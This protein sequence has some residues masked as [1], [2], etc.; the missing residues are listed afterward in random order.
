MGVVE[1]DIGAAVLVELNLVFFVKRHCSFNFE[2][3][4]RLQIFNFDLDV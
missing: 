2:A 1:D 3:L 4:L